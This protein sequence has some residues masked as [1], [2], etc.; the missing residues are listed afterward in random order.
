MVLAP[1]RLR[2]RNHAVCLRARRSAGSILGSDA[3]LF[4]H[5]LIGGIDGGDFL[6]REGHKFRWHTTRDH[7]VRVNIDDE[8]A[9]VTLQHVIVDFGRYPQN[10]VRIAFSRTH[11]ARFDV[12]EL[13]SGEPEALGYVS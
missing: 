4:S 12:A 11:M 7:L 6:G 3:A 10:L 9:V 5:L 2:T 1:S 13:G 8:L